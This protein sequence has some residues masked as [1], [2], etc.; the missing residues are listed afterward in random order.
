MSATDPSPPLHAESDGSLK[1]AVS[2]MSQ[3]VSLNVQA[4]GTR[5][6]DGEE[7]VDLKPPGCFTCICC[8]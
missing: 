3:M 7:L 8:I 4:G 1:D 5:H 6:A 2:P